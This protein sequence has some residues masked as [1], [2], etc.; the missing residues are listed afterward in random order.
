MQKKAFQIYYKLADKGSLIALNIKHIVMKMG[1]V[2]KNEEKA[3]ETYL[4]SAEKGYHVANF[5]LEQQKMKPNNNTMCNVGCCYENMKK[6]HLNGCGTKKVIIN[7]I[8]LLNKAN[9][10]GIWKPMN[11]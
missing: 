2:L 3:F 6:K 4:K 9:E 5:L 8:Y 11:Y 7:A 1:L 10:N